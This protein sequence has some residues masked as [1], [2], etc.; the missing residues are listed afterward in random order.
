MCITTTLKHTGVPARTV[1]SRSPRRAGQRAG[2]G[3]IDS[4]ESGTKRCRT[5]KQKEEEGGGGVYETG[6]KPD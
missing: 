2:E 4:E 6:R 3:E 1:T 5:L